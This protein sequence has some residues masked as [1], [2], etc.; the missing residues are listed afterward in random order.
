MGARFITGKFESL[1]QKLLEQQARAQSERWKRRLAFFGTEL[2]NTRATYL[3]YAQ[4]VSEFKQQW[5]EGLYG[6]DLGGMFMTALAI[7]GGFSVGH[8]IGKGQ[9]APFEGSYLDHSDSL[10]HPPE[11]CLMAF[12]CFVALFSSDDFTPLLLFCE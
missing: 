8:T 11:V 10:S 6:R 1:G 7:L 3:E 12:L 4:G 5:A 2:V 9:L